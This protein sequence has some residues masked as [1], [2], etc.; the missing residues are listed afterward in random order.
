MTRTTLSLPLMVRSRTLRTLV[1]IVGLAVAI[2]ASP[3][4]PAAGLE[5]ALAGG[6]LLSRPTDH[7][8][9][10]RALAAR[11]LTAEVEW[12]TTA[13]EY[14]HT[15]AA[16]HAEGGDPFEIVLSGLAPDTDYVYRLRIR[17]DDQPS[18]PQLG[19]GRTF[20]TQRL[21]GSPFTFVV[22]TDSHLDENSNPEV[23]AQA[24]RN[25]LADHPDFMV[26]LGDTA[27]TDRCVI[28]GTDLCSRDRA[29]AY[30][31]IAGRNALMRSYFAQVGHSLQLFLVLG[32]H[33][34][35]AGWIEDGGANNLSIWGVRARKFF[36]ANPEPDRFYSGNGREDPLVGR[37]QNYYAFEWGDALFVALDPFSNTTRKPTRFTDADMW[38]W[39][40]GDEQYHWLERT[41]AESRARFKFVFSHHMTG[42]SGP[43]ARGGAAFARNFEWGGRNIDGSWGFTDHRPGWA[44]P[45]HQLLVDNHVTIWFH[46]HDHVYVQEML[47][48]VVYQEV[49]QPSTRRASAADLAAEYGYLGTS[50][51]NAFASSGHLR[52]SVQPAEVRVTYVRAV[53][54]GEETPRVHNAEVVTSYVTR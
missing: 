8:I 37:R 25:A 42:G 34:G 36:Y 7:D 16:V 52:V 45:I 50:G 11:S 26:D 32:N 10:V 20:H 23:Y 51:V 12:G 14:D 38:N 28:G 17:P 33:E 48:G 30:E 22:Q 44:K 15:S 5:E 31:Q 41:L 2:W 1:P 3:S 46:G 29:T 9:M 4:M 27:M 21:A 18:T 35:E 40:L 49:P 53:A 54:P 13:G 39:T 43:E 24:L 19:P 47:D 6:E